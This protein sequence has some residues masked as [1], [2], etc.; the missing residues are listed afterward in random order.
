ML[1]AM[2]GHQPGALLVVVGPTAAGKTAWAIDHAQRQDAAVISADSRQVYA[3]M[4]MGTGKPHSAHRREQHD[5]LVPDVVEGVP[6]YLTNVAR[7]DHPLTIAQWQALAYTVIDHVLAQGSA[8]LLVGGTMLY[9]D[10]V[11]LNYDIPAVPPQAPLRAQLEQQ[12]TEALYAKLIKDDPDSA[13]FVPRANRRRM[14]R[15]LEVMAA[16]GRPF[17]A[18]RQRRTP[19]YAVRMVG[20]NPGWQQL[21]K[22]IRQRAQAMV[23]GGLIEETQR[24]RD[25]YG[26]TLPLLQTLNY[27]QAGAVL[28]GVLSW[29]E[30]LA[31]M[32]RANL[33]YAHRQMSWWRRRKEIEW[34]EVPQAISLTTNPPKC[35]P[36][37]PLAHPCDRRH[38]GCSP[39]AAGGKQTGL[40]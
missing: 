12:Q 29:K 22:N 33:R 13:Q 14:I 38:T 16:T 7:P 21:E 27:R 24:L 15:A 17:S 19:R 10:S 6:H 5:S 8:P 23:A 28:D 3:G 35:L 9:M 2:T 34:I 32:V 20:L 11:V 40:V 4:D 18:Q 37:V 25:R 36:D 1:P 31:A 26:K 39:G 30:A